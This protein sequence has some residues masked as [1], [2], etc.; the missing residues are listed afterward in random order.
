MWRHSELNSAFENTLY[1]TLF[2]A[3]SWESPLSSLIVLYYQ[4]I[5][6]LSRVKK[7]SKI[8]KARANKGRTFGDLGRIRT[9]DP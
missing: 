9:Y 6:M 4:V 1:L 3:K 8:N 2:I 5:Y 7:C